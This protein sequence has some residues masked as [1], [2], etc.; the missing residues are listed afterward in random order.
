M[1]VTFKIGCI[2]MTMGATGSVS[3]EMPPFYLNLMALAGSFPFPWPPEPGGAWL[4]LRC[5]RAFP[6]L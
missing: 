6:R 5:S 4:P 2:R 3:P 1:L